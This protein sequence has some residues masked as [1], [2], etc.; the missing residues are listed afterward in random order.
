MLYSCAQCLSLL[1]HIETH[2]MLL[3][4]NTFFPSLGQGPGSVCDGD[5]ENLYRE[6]N[7]YALVRSG[8][9]SSMCTKGMFIIRVSVSE[10]PLV[11]S[12]GFL[13]I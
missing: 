1:L 9:H 2:A 13:F 12:T 3:K 5:I 4:W 7:K 10:S 11:E 6:V 8:V